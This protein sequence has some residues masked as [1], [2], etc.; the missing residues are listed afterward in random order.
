M[1]VICRRHRLPRR[2]ISPDGQ[3]RL[4]AHNWP[5]NVRE[6]SHELERAIVFNEGV[7][8]DFEHLCGPA[9]IPAGVA[10]LAAG[11]GQWLNPAF[12]FPDNG[13]SLEDAIN[14]L[15]S[16]ALQQTD[17]NVSAAARLLGVSRDYVRYRLSGLKSPDSAGE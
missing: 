9:N 15:I 16:L 11:A 14:S 17:G 12:R 4:M 6:L 1:G 3:R 2:E 5:G 13:F 8:L 10:G 7:R